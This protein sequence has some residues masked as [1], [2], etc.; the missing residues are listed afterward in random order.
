MLGRA[1]R[2]ASPSAQ[3]GAL[4][5]ILDQHRL[6]LDSV[7]VHRMTGKLGPSGIPIGLRRLCRVMRQHDIRVTPKH[8]FKDRPAAMEV[9]DSGRDVSRY[10]RCVFAVP[11][12]TG[13]DEKRLRLRI[14]VILSNFAGCWDRI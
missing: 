4:A 8:H 5:K 2:R 14:S 9:I 12:Q 13:H 10:G 1:G 11:A 6:S 7:G 3:S